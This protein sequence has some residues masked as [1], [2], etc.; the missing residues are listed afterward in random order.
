MWAFCPICP[1]DP[2]QPAQ[3]TSRRVAQEAQP[4]GD[5][6]PRGQPGVSHLRRRRTTRH[7]ARSCPG[8]PSSSRRQPASRRG[9]RPPGQSSTPIAGVEAADS[10]ERTVT[11][12]ERVCRQPRC[13]RRHPRQPRPRDGRNSDAAPIRLCRVLA[14]FGTRER[15]RGPCF[16]QHPRAKRAPDREYIYLEQGQPT[17]LRALR[18]GGNPADGHRRLAQ[19]LCWLGWGGSSAGQ[20]K[21]LI[22]PGS[23]VRAPPAPLDRRRSTA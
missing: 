21:G 17:A 16:R 13:P 10:L 2:K 12:R 1:P 15:P 9:N 14:A 3:A 5:R 18:F 22:I 4:G 23:W 6:Q 19:V 20:S 11:T 7:G 8:P